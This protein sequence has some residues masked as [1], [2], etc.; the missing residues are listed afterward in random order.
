MLAPRTSVFVITRLGNWLPVNGTP[1]DDPLERFVNP[2]ALQSSAEIPVI[3]STRGTGYGPADLH[4]TSLY[5]RSTSRQSC[6]APPRN[7][8]RLGSEGALLSCTSSRR[9]ES[10]ASPAEANIPTLS[11][12]RVIRPELVNFPDADFGPGATPQP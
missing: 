9:A 5:P 6:P 3:G 1:T 12:W 8:V 11:E 10:S 7:H 2:L 4:H